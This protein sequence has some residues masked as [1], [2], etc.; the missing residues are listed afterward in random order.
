MHP[1]ESRWGHKP[2]VPGSQES[3]LVLRLG[4]RYLPGVTAPPLDVPRGGAV[5]LTDATR[6]RARE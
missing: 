5:D 1:F 3:L 2:L 4:V 6:G